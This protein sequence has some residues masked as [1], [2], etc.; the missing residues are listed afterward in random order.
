M[1]EPETYLTTI[2]NINPS[3]SLHKVIIGIQP[4]MIGSDYLAQ[5]IFKQKIRGY[6]QAAF[7]EGFFEKESIVLLPE[8]IG[9]WLVIEGEK[10]KIAKEE[11]LKDAMTTLV[12]SNLADFGLSTINTGEEEDK[13]ASAIFRMKAKKMAVSYFLTFSELAKEYD[14]YIVAGSIVLPGPTVIDGQLFVDLNENL[15]NV[16]FIFSPEGEIVGEPIIKAFPIVTEQPFITGTDPSS[17]ATFD[18]PIGKTA[19]LVCAD[20]WFPDAY[21]TAKSE[22]AEI[23]L[24]PS[25]C[26]GENT[27]KALWQG[28]SGHKEPEFTDLKDIGEITEIQAW[29]KYALPGQIRSTSAKIGMNVFL[30]GELWDLGTDGQPLVI[31]NGKLIPVESAEKGGIW[32]LNF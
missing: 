3:D 7:K 32:A 4:F 12:I 17:Y 21:K 6:F 20:S 31:Q 13:A 11:T 29:E 16:S 19:V 9:T 26:T 23:I 25:F 1:P 18:L 24:V 30:R 8:F 28:Y 5:P 15:R 22:Q 27:M 14:T 10:H 2:Q